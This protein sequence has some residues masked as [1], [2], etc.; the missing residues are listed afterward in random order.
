MESRTLCA[1][2]QTRECFLGLEVAAAEFSFVRLGERLQ[3]QAPK[4]GEGLW[5]TPFRGIPATGLYTPLD[6]IYLDT[7]CHVIEVVESFPSVQA[8]PN[9][10]TAASVL[11]LPAHSIYSSQTQVGDQLVLCPVE[12]LEW[13]L[14]RFSGSKAE[15]GTVQEAAVLREQP[16]WSVGPGVAELGTAQEQQTGKTLETHEMNLIS[17][18]NQPGRRLRNWLERWW[19]PDPRKAPRMPLPGLAAYYWNGTAPQAHVVRDISSTGLY[20]ETEDRWYPGTLVLMTLQRAEGREEV[21]ERALAV[22]SRAVRWGN[23]GVGL[24]F[25]LADSSQGRTLAGEGANKKTLAQFLEQLDAG[26]S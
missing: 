17:S 12:E 22:M 19:S 5:L 9:T 6:L 15:A 4:S 2:N 10:P 8:S 24:Q 13:R 16:L 23:D 14:E 26:K 25:I 1:Y 7:D 11:V 21:A 3:R 18:P 20:L